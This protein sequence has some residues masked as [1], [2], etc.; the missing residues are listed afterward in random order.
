M[1]KKIF[2]PRSFLGKFFQI[3]KQICDLLERLLPGEFTRSLLY[4]HEITAAEKMNLRSGQVVVDIGGGHKAPFARRRRRDL[5]TLLIGIDILPSQVRN[6]LSI[7]VGIVADVCKSI[8]LR[9][10]SVDLFVL[11]S[12]IEHLPEKSKLFFEISRCL[13]SGGHSVIVLPCCFSPFSIINR[14]LPASMARGLLHAL[15][16]KWTDAC[17]FEPFY[18]DCYFPRLISLIKNSELYTVQIEFRY[19]QAI[20][21][22]FFVPF[23]CLFVL[24]DLILWSLNIRMLAAQMFIVVQRQ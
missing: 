5:N 14:F 21:F 24:Y 3:N 18:R 1:N 8:P 16:P 7:D 4:K 15:F 12:V 9:D 20:Y 19:Y 11:R 17:G 22:K 6:N 10:M 13:K 23:Y 2:Y